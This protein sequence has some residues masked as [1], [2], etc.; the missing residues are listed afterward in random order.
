MLSIY[1]GN[2]VNETNTLDI[3]SVGKVP[4]DCDTLVI[5][6]PSKDFDDVATNA[7]LDYINKGGNILWM[8]AAIATEVDFPNVD[9][10][11][12]QC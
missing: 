8:N 6:S 3:L 7:I 4:D 1:L 10:Y 2:E 9:V 11:K 12:R 5:T